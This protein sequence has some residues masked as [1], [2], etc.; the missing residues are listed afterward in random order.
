MQKIVLI[1]AA[2]VG[3]CG[4]GLGAAWGWGTSDLDQAQ[5]YPEA[6]IEQM[7]AETAPEF[8]PLRDNPAV[9]SIT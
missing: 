4:V 7:E 1:V 3:V 2:L 6:L 9:N 5:I 8:I